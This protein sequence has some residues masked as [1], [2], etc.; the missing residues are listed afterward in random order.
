MTK[1]SLDVLL[2]LVADSHRR[3]VIQQLRS[4]A[5]GKTMIDDLVDAM[6]DSG[7]GTDEQTIEREQLLIQ[8]YHAH[9]P[10]L[11]D[12]GIV[13]FEPGNRTVRYQPDEQVETVLDSLPV[14]RPVAHP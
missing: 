6:C 12:H 10:K 7:S 14:E 4:E 3:E 11:A 2:Q 5:N 9:L 8:L 1:R 13:E